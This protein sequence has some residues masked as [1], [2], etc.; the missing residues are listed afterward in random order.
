LFHHQFHADCRSE[1]I[2]TV[3]SIHSCGNYI[4]IENVCDLQ[5][6]FSFAGGPFECR[7]IFCAASRK[8]VQRNDLIAARNQRFAKMTPDESS[9]ASDK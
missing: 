1:V 6:K 2:D 5:A 7:N 4:N 9:A 3:D 8:I